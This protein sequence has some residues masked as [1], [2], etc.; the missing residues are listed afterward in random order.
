[1]RPV[2]HTNSRDA[3]NSLVQVKRGHTAATPAGRGMKAGCGFR[4]ASTVHPCLP[5]STRD[6]GIRVT[7]TRPCCLQAQLELHVTL[8]PY[9]DFTPCTKGTVL[10]PLRALR[11]QAVR[12]RTLEAG[13]GGRLDTCRR[14]Q[15]SGECPSFSWHCRLALVLSS[16][17]YDDQGSA[18]TPWRR[19][20]DHCLFAFELV[21]RRGLI[22]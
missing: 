10:Q 5:C 21:V 3:R 22:Y 17:A 19:G 6:G 12:R 7:H 15:V 14:C 8:L 18:E 2:G 20:L 16:A 4:E 1:M 13:G 11:C 9:I